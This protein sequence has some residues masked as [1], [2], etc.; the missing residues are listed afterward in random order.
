MVDR[1][2][3]QEAARN[4]EY[5][6]RLDAIG[7]PRRSLGRAMSD[8]QLLEK[9]RSF[10]LELDQATL[11]EWC[12]KVP[13][14]QELSEQLRRTRPLRL[15]E[16]DEDWLWICLVVLW[17]RWFPDLP[18]FERIDDKMQAGYDA[19][20]PDQA[21]ACEVWLDTWRDILA[22]MSSHHIE[23][24]GELDEEFGGTQCVSNWIQDFTMHLWNA[25]L[26]DPRFL[27]ERIAVCEE[28][29]LRWPE[30]SRL[31]VE[32]LRA[33]MADA[34]FRLGATDR[35]S[36]WFQQWLDEDPRWGSGWIRWSNCYARRFMGNR[37][38]EEAQRILQRGLAVP[39]VRDRR[40]LLERLADLYEESGEGDAT[41]K[42]RAEAASLADDFAAVEVSETGSVLG[43]KTALTSG[44]DGLPLSES[45][46]LASGL[47]RQHIQHGMHVP[48]VGR[49]A[50]CPCGSG[51]KYKKCCGRPHS[52]GK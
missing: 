20:E 15:R 43:M 40:R 18:N 32:N 19:V 9:L 24:L 46:N 22:L 3:E 10:G 2:V 47:R 42:L 37:D 33:D 38:P 34:S 51:R 5:R 41:A 4:P 50:P 26:D 35:A 36:S 27:R 52:D 14:A 28:A 39:G 44:E 45:G 7:K 6:R 49:N 11:G 48:Q 31:L 17:E 25:G 21:R 12:R 13:S 29:L 23:T 8:E 1:I 16:M 30:A